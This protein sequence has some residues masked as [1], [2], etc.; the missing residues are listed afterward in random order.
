MHH[1]FLFFSTRMVDFIC[2]VQGLSL[3]KI[4]AEAR[5]CEIAFRKTYNIGIETARERD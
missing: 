3:E 1:D 2:M 5:E 4:T